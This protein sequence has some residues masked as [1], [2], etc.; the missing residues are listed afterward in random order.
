[1]PGVDWM[2]PHGGELAGAFAAGCAFITGIYGGFTKAAWDKMVSPRIKDLEDRL[3]AQTNRLLEV[4]SEREEDRREF[5]RQRRQDRDECRIET[6]R[7]QGKVDRLEEQL[8]TIMLVSNP[9]AIRAQVQG[10]ISETRVTQI[11]EGAYKLTNKDAA[12]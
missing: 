11:A 5:E 12:E 4:E 2:G 10:V 7:L 6:M 1:M 9:P 8:R 3:A